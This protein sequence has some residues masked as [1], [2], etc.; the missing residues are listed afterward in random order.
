MKNALKKWLSA[1][2]FTSIGIALGIALGA[3]KKSGKACKSHGNE[4][5]PKQKITAH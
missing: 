1:S 3:G 2:V 4:Q 5:P